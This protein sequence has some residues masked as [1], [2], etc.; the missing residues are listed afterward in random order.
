MAGN[1]CEDRRLCHDKLATLPVSADVQQMKVL[2]KLGIVV[3][4]MVI[5]ENGPGVVACYRKNSGRGRSVS[6]RIMFLSQEADDLV[7][8]GLG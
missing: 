8:G 6:A 4:V 3:G 2:K 5:R 1:T 7:G